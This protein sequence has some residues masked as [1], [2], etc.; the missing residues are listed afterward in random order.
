MKSSVAKLKLLE[1]FCSMQQFIVSARKYRP[2]TFS[3]VVGQKHVA[4][5]LMHEI[6]GNKL[7][8]AFLFTGPRG[9]GKTTCARILAKVINTQSEN[10]DPNQDFAFNIFELDAAS[11]NSVEDIRHL[12]DQVRIPPQVGKYKVYIIDE[13]HML[14]AAAFNAFLK[15]LE[16]P[17]SYAIFIL[18]TTEKH[19]ILPTILSR[20]QVFN[21]NRIEASDMVEHLKMIAKNENIVA[22]EDALH[23]VARKAD[24]GLRDALSLFDQLV[25]F[26]QGEV[27]YEKAVE[28]LNILDVD[29]FF[30]VTDKLIKQNIAEAL[31]I[32]DDILNQGF[33]GSLFVSG[34]AQHYRNLM[35][36][37]DESTLKLLDVSQA[38][39]MKYLEQAKQL[40]LGFIINALNLTNETDEK[41]KFSRN[42]RLL[43]ELMLIKL[44]H[45]SQ[46]IAEIPTLEDIKKKLANPTLQPA[47]A[48]TAGTPVNVVKDRAVPTIKEHVEEKLSS[49]RLGKLDRNSFKQKKLEKDNEKASE[50][51]DN[52]T[53][54]LVETV[55]E[56][57]DGPIPTLNQMMSEFS[58]TQSSRV[59]G[60]IKSVLY[61]LDGSQ[62]V[63]TV[64]SKAQELAM[65]DIRIPLLHFL[66]KKS[67][68]TI[69]NVITVLG[70]VEET[71]KRPYTDKEKLDYFLKKHSEL[72]EVIEKLHL[73]LL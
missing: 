62:V 26:S 68:N 5:T 44:A 29:T 24:G 53:A 48:T 69:N 60:L 33:D 38:F 65:E 32:F 27:T 4:E 42:P 15:T 22:S 41:Y 8:Q 17:P 61:A 64:S 59:G 36:C 18:A 56:Y 14:S 50:N 1:L 12:I 47:S 13:V 3:D 52:H 51:A 45:L 54:A 55:I 46:F 49:T 30:G 58:A 25:S 23:L 11:N 72:N 2:T 7:A 10:A 67:R 57:N 35:V 21:F 37:K 71:E 63:V 28:I 39:K 40:D 70:E 73:R 19:K 9:V 66:L 43:I 6:T 31:L 34:M 20:C 16:E